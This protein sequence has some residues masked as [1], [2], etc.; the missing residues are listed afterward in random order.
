MDDDRWTQTGYSRKTDERLKS[1][2]V[3]GYPI[4][5]SISLFSPSRMGSPQ[6]TSAVG[7]RFDDGQID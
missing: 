5:L 1:V 2:S 7:D 4:Y 3:S 6:L